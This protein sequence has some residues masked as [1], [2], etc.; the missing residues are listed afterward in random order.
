M[1]T[2]LHYCHHSVGLGHLVRSTAV[3]EALAR[4]FRVVLCIGGPVPAGVRAP[5]G[6]E[7]V[8]L[9]PIAAAPGGGLRSLD[10]RLTLEQAWDSRRERL[11]ALYRELLPAALVVELFPFGRA[12][13]ASEL[14]PLLSA[15]RGDP[16]PV[17]VIA[18]VRDLLVANKRDQRAHDDLAA[19]RLTAYFD[20][21]VVHADARFA[22][23]EETFRPSLFP[24]TPVLYSGFVTPSTGRPAREPDP[25]PEVL[26]SAGGGL[27]GAPLLHAAAAA[28]RECLATLGLRTRLVTGPFLP[29]AE[30][31]GLRELAAAVPGL[32]LQEFIPDLCSAMARAAVS[33][34]RGGYNTMIDVLRAG[35]PAVVVPYDDRGDQEQTERARRL[36]RLGV[37]A[38][39]PASELTP[40]RLA[41]AILRA[42]EAEPS[43]VDLDLDGAEKTARIVLDL[44]E[45]ASPR[46]MAAAAAAS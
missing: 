25:L 4:S 35:A 9:A 32:S 33:V 26:V 10:P 29:A 11:L 38:V 42:L 36:A 28:H 14:L 20:A 8:A 31:S 39:L 1:P 6:V 40:E 23:L 16:R 5:N 19:A 15:A 18:S 7:L 2:L 30:A 45:A 43:P 44:V 37:L 13:F 21:V 12:K 41:A 3:A 24:P 46:G 34:S 22:R 27:H 17:Q